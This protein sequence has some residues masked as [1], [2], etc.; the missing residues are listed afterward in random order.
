MTVAMSPQAYLQMPDAI[1]LQEAVFSLPVPM[2]P[3]PEPIMALSLA[4]VDPAASLFGGMK[5]VELIGNEQL[6]GETPSIHIRGVQRDGVI[7]DLWISTQ[8]DHR[9]LRLVVDLTEMLKASGQ[10]AVPDNF[11]F[12]LRA[13]FSSWRMSGEVDERLFRYTPPEGA[14]KFK[15]LEAYYESIA[16]VVAEHPL[17]GKP[18]PPLQAKTIGGDEVR[19]DGLDGKVVILDFWATWC[20]PCIAAVPVIEEV[21]GQFNDKGVVYYAVNTGED[22]ELVKGFVEQQGWKVNVLIDPAETIAEAFQAD[23]IPQTVIIGKDGIVESVHI[24]FAG[25]DALRKRLID[26]LD[27]LS[28]GGR[29]ASAGDTETPPPSTPPN[30]S[31]ETP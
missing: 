29:I 28:I 19:S 7:W 18:S 26:E 20:K 11:S 16:G 22:L 4:S 8:E 25:A 9:P 27:V 14:V 17:L 21:A 6:R 13:D 31:D 2:G 1:G 30:R 3:Y 5:S 10:V 15:S 12:R 24:G 23:A